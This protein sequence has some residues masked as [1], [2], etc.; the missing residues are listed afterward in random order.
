MT[1][2]VAR[3]LSAGALHSHLL[4]GH[5]EELLFGDSGVMLDSICAFGGDQACSSQ[6]VNHGYFNDE[7]CNAY[8]N[9]VC[10]PF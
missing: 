3:R 1:V 4:S 8:N 7:H 2:A 10:N 5:D 9:C 6:C